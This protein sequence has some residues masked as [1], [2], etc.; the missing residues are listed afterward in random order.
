M[1]KCCSEDKQLN[2]IQSRYP[3]I[4]EHDICFTFWLGVWEEELH[5]LTSPTSRGKATVLQTP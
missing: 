4:Y 5:T 2:K 1:C 3:F